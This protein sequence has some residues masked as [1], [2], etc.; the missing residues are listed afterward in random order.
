MLAMTNLNLVN[1]SFGF[2]LVQFHWVWAYFGSVRFG[3]NLFDSVP[4]RICVC[5]IL[6]I[7]IILGRLML[8]RFSSV[9]VY[10]DSCLV[11]TFFLMQFGYELGHLV[12]VSFARSKQIGLWL[13]FEH[14]LVLMLAP[15]RQQFWY[16]EGYYFFVL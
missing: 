5:F 16:P 3:P 12:W 8:A 14:V 9:R 2:G 11:L 6:I 4:I 15:K 7:Y 1:G 13:G 10:S